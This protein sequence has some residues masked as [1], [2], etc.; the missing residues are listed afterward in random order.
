MYLFT[1]IHASCSLRNPANTFQDLQM[2][3]KGLLQPRDN[4]KSRAAREPP[5]ETL[6]SI[7]LGVANSRQIHQQSIHFDTHTPPC[8]RNRVPLMNNSMTLLQGFGLVMQ[9]RGIG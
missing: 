5:L 1:Y 6:E 8:A 4:Q 7:H 3:Q 2:L 9:F